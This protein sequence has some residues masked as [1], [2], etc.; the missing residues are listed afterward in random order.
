MAM[1]SQEYEMLV[2]QAHDREVYEQEEKRMLSDAIY[3]VRVELRHLRFIQ[4]A[5]VVAVL[6]VAL[7]IFASDAHAA[8]TRYQSST[9]P[10]YDHMSTDAWRA[11]LVDV[12]AA[13]DAID[14]IASPYV[15]KPKDVGCDDGWDVNPPP[16]GDPLGV[17]SVCNRNWGQD[18][19]KALTSVFE[20]NGWFSWTLI[21]MNDAYYPT[22]WG[23]R[24]FLL[25]HEMC[26]AWG[27]L[28]TDA[29]NADGSLRKT[30]CM[31]RSYDV[32][33]NPATFDP[34]KPDPQDKLNISNRY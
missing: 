32:D 34:W 6:G 15:A 12:T 33:A 26:H 31:R 21:E 2:E 23:R 17:I 24:H 10:V 11:T 14:K 22:N 28:H 16:A 5:L 30:S 13:F 29:F 19:N 1:H 27:L 25:S 7:A 20:M 8:A 18:G 3:G 9:V 4:A